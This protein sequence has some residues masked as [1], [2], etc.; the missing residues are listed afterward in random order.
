MLCL[1]R[2]GCLHRHNELGQMQD[3]A[4]TAAGI[5]VLVLC[6]VFVRG[7][8]SDCVGSVCLP[9]MSVFLVAAGIHSSFTL[10]SAWPSACSFSPGRFDTATYHPVTTSQPPDFSYLAVVSYTFCS[11]FWRRPLDAAPD[12]DM[13]DQSPKSTTT[14]TSLST[15]GVAKRQARRRQRPLPP[16]ANARNLAIQKER[17]DSLN[18]T[19]LVGSCRAAATLMVD[20]PCL[21]MLHLGHGS[22]ASRLGVDQST[23]QEAHNH[24]GCQP[25]TAATEPVHICFRRREGAPE[26]E[27]TAGLRAQHGVLTATRRRG[28]AAAGDQDGHRGLGKADEG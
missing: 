27:P 2:L 16:D 7:K 5:C 28:D 11:F 21:P 6:P 15:D 17:R 25:P 14:T 10:S 4:R 13:A 18:E 12:L 1:R 26:R 8:E 19:L 23:L 24:R 3:P 9:R 22:P 20:N